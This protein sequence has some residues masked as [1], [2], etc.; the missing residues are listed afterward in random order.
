MLERTRRRMYFESSERTCNQMILSIALSLRESIVKTLDTEAIVNKLRSGCADKVACWNELKILAIA[1]SAV[2][3]YSHAMLVTF[4]RIQVNLMSGHM[5]KD[6]QNMGN[7]AAENAVQTKYMSLFSSFLCNGIKKLSILIKD[8]VAEIT[9][10][11][12]LKDELTLRDLEQIYWA[13]ASSISANNSK[14][15]VKNLASYMLPSNRDDEDCPILTKMINETLDLL[16][17]EEVQN[18]IQSNIRSGFVL[19]IDHI[20]E[21]FMGTSKNNEEIVQ[22]GVSVPGTS[23]SKDVIWAEGR[24]T[25]K[26]HHFGTAFIDINKVAMPMA[27]IIPIIN[28]QVPDKGTPKDVPTDWLQQ[29]ILNNELKTLGAN[30]YEAF[31]F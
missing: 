28:G 27:K 5:Y 26:N 30:I 12:S 10:S 9:A 24:R 14:D 25:E 21:Y 2:T 3:I 17:S 8:K 23:A 29:L 31:S 18:L 7:T 11:M 13:I 22:N 1:R 16:E 15:P 19:L 4:V 20:A 6:T